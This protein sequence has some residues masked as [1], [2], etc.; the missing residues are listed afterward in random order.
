MDH[1]PRFLT[2]VESIR[3]SVRECSVVELQ[4]CIADGTARVFDVREDH[5]WLAGH[6]TGAEHLG[7]GIIERDIERTVPDPSAA[8]VL[9]CGGGFRSALAADALQRM[10]YTNV[11]SLSGGWRAWCD[12]GGHVTTRATS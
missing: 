6:A 10:G 5:E 1:T 11:R 2:L 8:I 9:Y 12:A 3:A 4:Q 7:K